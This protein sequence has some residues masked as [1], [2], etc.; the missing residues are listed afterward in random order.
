[1]NEKPNSVEIRNKECKELADTLVKKIKNGEYKTWVDAYEEISKYPIEILSRAIAP[2]LVGDEWKLIRQTTLLQLTSHGEQKEKRKRR[3]HTLLLGSAGTGKTEMLLFFF[4]N[5][6]GV[7]VNSENT[8]K[9]GLVG[10]A[11]GSEAT[12]GLLAQYNGQFILLDE[13]DKMSITDQNGLL[14]AMEEGYYRIIKGQ[15][16]Q[17][18]IAEIRVIA[19][20]NEIKKIQ[21]PLLDRFD[22]IYRCTTSTRDDRAKNVPKITESFFDSNTDSWAELVRGYMAWLGNTTPKGY[23]KESKKDIDE[24]IARYIKRVKSVDVER[25]SYRFLEMSILRTSWAIAKIHKREVI[26]KEDVNRAIWYKH[27]TMTRIYG[28]DLNKKMGR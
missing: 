27:N 22:F 18:F 13:L 20:A 28:I 3:L 17:R 4:Q 19:S 5:I 23:E 25:A 1:M 14:Q 15:I 12:P 8:S 9:I 7:I 16:R 24:L 2:H 21:L 11:R 26:T 10:D 6:G